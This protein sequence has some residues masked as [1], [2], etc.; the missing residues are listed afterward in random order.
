MYLGDDTDPILLAEKK[1]NSCNWHNAMKFLEYQFKDE[2][3][4]TI[5]IKEVK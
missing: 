1:Y 4:I 3:N 5:A 2:E